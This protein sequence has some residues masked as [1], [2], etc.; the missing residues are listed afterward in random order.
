MCLETPLISVI[1]PW[2]REAPTEFLVRARFGLN[3]SPFTSCFTFC[4]FDFFSFLSFSASQVTVLWYTP[5]LE[6][7][8]FSSCCSVACLPRE[9]CGLGA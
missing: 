8:M 6:S 4:F 9:V 7:L 5:S 1:G 3:E 2:G